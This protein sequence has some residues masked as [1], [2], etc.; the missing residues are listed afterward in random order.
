V[1]NNSALLGAINVST[2]TIDWI[3]IQE[4]F[5][6]MEATSR[7]SFYGNG[8]RRFNVNHTVRLPRESSQ[9]AHTRF[10]V[11]LGGMR[12]VNASGTDFIVLDRWPS[13]MAKAHQFALYPLDLSNGI[14][15]GNG[16]NTNS[17]NVAIRVGANIKGS[18]KRLYAEYAAV[19]IA[20]YF[21]LMVS[22]EDC[23]FTGTGLYTIFTSDAYSNALNHTWAGT[24]N[25]NSQCNM[26]DYKR[27]R[28]QPG[29]AS[30]IISAWYIK[31]GYDHNIERS[32]AENLGGTAQHLIFYEGSGDQVDHTL[33][34]NGFYYEVTGSVTR[35]VIR[36]RNEKGIATIN[37]VTGYISG[38]MSAFIEG[39]N[40]GGTGTPTIV[41]S[42]CE[43][44]HT[45]HKYRSVV[46]SSSAGYGLQAQ[47]MWDFDNV[48][49]PEWRNA[50][51]ATNWITS[52]TPVWNGV[53]ENWVVPDKSHLRYKGMF[54]DINQ[55]LDVGLQDLPKYTR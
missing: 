6:T 48:G 21:N 22:M 32:N 36:V 34:V 30:T 25:S 10:T 47:V 15:I 39:D 20:L 38:T 1:A 27:V 5:L 19:N 49:M 4:A 33:T 51:S 54:Y 37:N 45:N 31:G 16:V 24:T 23:Q 3:A 55:Q 42:N 52:G 17:N 43:N 9:G 29:G 41:V 44:A 46:R 7:T 8:A 18:Y 28:C 13:D 11:D 14:V 2:M 53:A 26:I 12:I 40:R 50:L 35:A